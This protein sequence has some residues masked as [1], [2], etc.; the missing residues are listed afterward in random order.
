M[1]FSNFGEKWML[2]LCA[3]LHAVEELDYDNYAFMDSDVYVQTD[4]SEIWKE[5]QEKIIPLDVYELPI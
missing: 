1:R 4:F 2:T 5:Y 3:L